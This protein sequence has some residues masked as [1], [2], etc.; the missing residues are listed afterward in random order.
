MLHYP[1]ELHTT[2]INYTIFL[3]LLSRNMSRL[4]ILVYV[5][6]YIQ[7]YKPVLN[8]NIPALY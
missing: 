1:C 7:L 4:N 2:Y 3:Y 5:T 6:M 8:N